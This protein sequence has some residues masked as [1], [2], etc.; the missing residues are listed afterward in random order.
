MDVSRIDLNRHDLFRL[1]LRRVDL[2][3]GRIDLFV[4]DLNRDDLDDFRIYLLGNFDLLRI[5][6]RRDGVGYVCGCEVCNTHTIL[7]STGPRRPSESVG[8]DLNRDRSC[9]R[10]AA[11]EAPARA[12]PEE[13]TNKS[14]SIGP[15]RF[16]FE[17]QIQSTPEGTLQEPHSVNFYW[18]CATPEAAP[19]ISR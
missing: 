4:L 17:S 15:V 8:A 1:D 18:L 7:L 12:L 3:F 5:D 16:E 19:D 13:W 9:A 6:L 2:S 10:R 14:S 11:S